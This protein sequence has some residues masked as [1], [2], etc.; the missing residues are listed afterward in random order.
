MTV[1]HATTDT[2]LSVFFSFAEGEPSIGEVGLTDATLAAMPNV[3]LVDGSDC[4]ETLVHWDYANKFHRLVRRA[5]NVQ[6]CKQVPG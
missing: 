2:V 6:H 3:E 5:K 4:L 1:Y